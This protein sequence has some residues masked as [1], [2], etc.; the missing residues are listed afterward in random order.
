[1]ERYIRT[2]GLSGSYFSKEYE[3]KKRQHKNKVREVTRNTVK[4][5]FLEGKAEV[6]VIF[7]ETDKELLLDQYSNEEDIKKYLGEDFLSND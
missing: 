1:M 7:E 5:F 2:I 4:K 6:L 3:K